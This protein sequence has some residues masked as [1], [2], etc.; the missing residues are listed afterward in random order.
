MTSVVD[1]N[2]NLIR[3]FREYRVYNAEFVICLFLYNK[4]Y[5]FSMFYTKKLWANHKYEM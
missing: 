2:T 4:P 5:I 3:Q 1:S